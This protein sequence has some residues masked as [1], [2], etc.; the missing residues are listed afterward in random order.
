MNIYTTQVDDA[1][2]LL[3]ALDAHK[4]GTVEVAAITAVCGNTG[5]HHALR[6]ILRTLGR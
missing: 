2:A 4:R 3:M 6:N 5:H 1:M